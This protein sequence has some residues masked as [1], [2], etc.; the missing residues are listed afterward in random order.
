MKSHP[1]NE[2]PQ[3]FEDDTVRPKPASRKLP[4]CIPSP[5]GTG[6]AGETCMSCR[7]LCRV[8]HNDYVYLKCGHMKH[9]WSRGAGTDIRAGWAACRQWE[10]KDRREVAQ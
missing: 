7:H 9:S 3:L 8:R 4:P 2:A 10:K 6:P 5:S 1:T